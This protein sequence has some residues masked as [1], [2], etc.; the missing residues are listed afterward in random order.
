MLRKCA[1]DFSEALKKHHIALTWDGKTALVPSSAHGAKDP[2][3]ETGHVKA[4]IRLLDLDLDC[5]RKYLP[6][7]A[8][9]LKSAAQAEAEAEGRE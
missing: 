8:H 3:I 2:E 6:E 1:K 7:I 9:R 4:M 5:V